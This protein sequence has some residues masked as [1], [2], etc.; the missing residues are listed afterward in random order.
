MKSDSTCVK[1]TYY[2]N[3]IVHS[4]EEQKIVISS[5]VKQYL[6]HGQAIKYYP[7]GSISRISFWKNDKEINYVGYNLN[8]QIDA[9]GIQVFYD[10]LF[11][12]KRFD[13]HDN[14]QIRYIFYEKD[15]VPIINEE[16]CD[17]GQLRFRQNVQFH[18]DH[19]EWVPDLGYTEYHC[20][21]MIHNYLEFS[22]FHG[23]MG[24]GQC[25]TYYDNGQVRIRYQR[26]AI[27]SNI[28]DD[29][30]FINTGTWK[31]FDSS[32]KLWKKVKY[33]KNVVIKEKI[34]FDCKECSDRIT[35][36]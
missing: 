20:N 18:S 36:G 19:S 29:Y 21:G 25:Y 31:Y 5:S 30:V 2:K 35:F 32:G 6:N 15:G 26:E 23:M 13:F 17:N 16:Y 33:K 8:G 24:Y 34:Y 3:G 11:N 12:F 4:K 28:A 10:T 1:E 14:G 27:W 7:D 22:M 9:L